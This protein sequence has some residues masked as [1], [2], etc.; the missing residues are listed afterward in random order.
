MH[1]DQRWGTSCTSASIAGSDSRAPASRSGGLRREFQ[2][3]AQGFIAECRRISPLGRG[4]FHVGDFLHDR[5]QQEN[6]I[7]KLLGDVSK[8]LSE[9]Q[10]RF[11]CNLAGRRVCRSIKFGGSCV[12][13]SLTLPATC[14]CSSVESCRHM[15][16]F[17]AGCKGCW[18]EPVQACMWAAVIV[19]GPPCRDDP[20]CRGP[21]F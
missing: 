20:A 9:Y 18:V 5:S 12:P 19:V 10:D 7:A 1:R 4:R 11:R 15:P 14:A 16:L 8:A 21:G 2:S 13:R 6:T 3:A 17:A